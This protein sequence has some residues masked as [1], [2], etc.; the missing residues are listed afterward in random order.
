MIEL[1]FPGHLLFF[2]GACMIELIWALTRD[3][4]DDGLGL[5]TTLVWGTYTAMTLLTIAIYG[6][7]FWW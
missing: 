7:V 3:C 4:S 2:I 1:T 5:K 6:G